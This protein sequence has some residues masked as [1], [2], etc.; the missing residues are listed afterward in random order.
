MAGYRRFV[1]Y[2][3]EY[4]DGKKGNG[5]GF[6]KVEARDGKCR[7]NYR[8][9][10]IYGKEEAPC[11][12]YGFVRK[13]DGCEGI[14]LGECD[15]A[16]DT[17]QFQ[18][19]VP[20]Q[21][22]GGTAYGLNDLS[23]L[24]MLTGDGIM[25]GTGWDDRPVRLEEIRLPR[26]Q[27]DRSRNAD[28]AT[29]TNNNMQKEELETGPEAVQDELPEGVAAAEALMEAEGPV[30][31]DDEE[32]S[33]PLA[34]HSEETVNLFSGESPDDNLEEMDYRTDTTV[35]IET[36]STNAGRA[37]RGNTMEGNRA[38]AGNAMEGN[39]AE[40]GNAMEGN[41]AEAGNA[42]ERNRAEAGNAMERNRAE[43][44]NAMEENRADGNN[45][46]GGNRTE[47]E[48]AMEADWEA[49]N[50]AVG[51][52][53]AERENAIEADWE[54]GNN[55]V[56][57]NRAGRNNSMDDTPWQGRYPSNTFRQGGMNT[58]DRNREERSNFSNA[59]H[60]DW[61][62]PPVIGRDNETS[63]PGR[64]ME[65]NRSN[66]S[67]ETEEGR[68]A[69]PSRT[70]GDPYMPP[71]INERGTY[72]PQHY[73]EDEPET[74][75]EER[76]EQRMEPV[77]PSRTEN[78][79]QPVMEPSRSDMGQ[80]RNTAI[81]NMGQNRNTAV[82]NMDQD[83]N[84]AIPDMNQNRNAAV[85]NM[86]QNRNTTMPDIN[87]N[88]N[89]TMP[90]IN[91]NR[92]TT[93]PDM[94]QNR[95]AAV[96][97]MG[98]DRN[99]TMPDINQNRNTTMPDMN[100]NRNA[101]VPNMG[102]NRNTT[103][104]DM[105]QNRNTAMP[106]TDR[107]PDTTAPDMERPPYTEEEL[108]RE[109]IDH[110][111]FGR[112][113]YPDSEMR[114]EASGSTDAAE[115][116][117]WNPAGDREEDA[118]NLLEEL[119]QDEDAIRNMRQMEKEVTEKT[120][121]SPEE[122]ELHGQSAQ[123]A[124]QPAV[125]APFS[126]GE[127]VDCRQITPAELRILARRDRGLMNNNFLRHGYYRYHYLLLGRRRDDGRYILGV[128]GVYDRQECLMAGMFGFPNFKAAKTQGKAAMPRFGYWYRLIDT[129]D[130]NR[131]NRS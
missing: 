120:V 110:E 89:T 91:Q 14:Y 5:K 106:D 114:I 45:A 104:P 122:G 118:V 71:R 18:T 34:E 29:E 66:E 2:V 20:D 81:P 99:T 60:R 33:L 57:G 115:Q 83:R 76:S 54:A 15:L 47:R 25:Y 28:R 7:M 51:G 16:G 98:Q 24:V 39:R 55:A 97:N 94:N 95:N 12:I 102:Q 53:R 43:T 116:S 62:Y 130:I 17:V 107:N 6:I 59:G 32:G 3:Y 8:I 63:A 113:Q 40:A 64:R 84:A 19:E 37:E 56:D 72:F 112:D 49:G 35:E 90:D 86:G 52:N 85:P 87:Q 96:P 69:M 93:M 127:I 128:P 117:T 111:I 22:M 125:F 1:A 82:P 42:M 77:A 13:S 105:N 9:Q 27:E 65:E 41:R 109:T 36:D 121:Q 58:P 21:G 48:N 31:L 70:E 103:M 67:S 50:N 68:Q 124:R 46:M 123:A 23:G 129:P 30:A 38:E 10:G 61:G 11:K 80:N 44:G 88:R 26:M 131:R 101:A 119:D 75:Q 108:Y 4:P 74:G 78:T 100:Q 126:D 73:E 92:N 79:V